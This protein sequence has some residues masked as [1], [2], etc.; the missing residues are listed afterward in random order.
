MNIQSHKKQVLNTNLATVRHGLVKSTFGNVSVINRAQDRLVIKPSGVPYDELT[1]DNM[2]VTDLAGL[3]I[4]DH[5]SNRNPSSDLAT[6]V[7]L[8]AAFENINTVIH[9]H[10]T[11][12]TIFAQMQRPIPALGTTHADYF[13]GPV[14]ITRALE[15]D[16]IGD[17]Y[18]AQTGRVIVETFENI[19]SD[20]IP[21]VLVAGHGPFV[22]GPTPEDALMNALMLEEAAKLAWH[23]EMMVPDAQPISQSLLDVHY[24]RKH[25]RSATYGQANRGT[26]T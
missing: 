20:E 10:S 12:A 14:P 1:V 22:W 11:Y 25:G 23:V 2:V 18:V 16:E 15:D 8:Y 6:H 19:S 9:T 7:V 24:F 3:P 13:R 4:P 17:D 5:Q 21:A 26:E